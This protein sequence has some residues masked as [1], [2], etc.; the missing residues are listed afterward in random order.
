MTFHLLIIQNTKFYKNSFETKSSV[1]DRR[2]AR[3]GK[4]DVEPHTRSLVAGSLK[5]VVA[6]CTNAANKQT[7]L[8]LNSGDVTLLLL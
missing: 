6:T 5:S 7:T 1:E 8:F 3:H 2:R 4:A